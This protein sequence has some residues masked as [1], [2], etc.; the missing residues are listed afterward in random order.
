MDNT[1]TVRMATTTSINNIN[2]TINAATD[3]EVD[4]DDD[5][6]D[7]EKDE[8]G[9][10]MALVWL[11][12]ITVLIS[13]L[14]DY[15]VDTIHSAAKSWGM[16]ALFLSAIVVP[17]IGNAA[18]HAGA[19]MFAMKNKVDLAL[20]IAVGSSTQIALMVLPLLVIIG[21]MINKPLNLD[22]ESF[23]ASTLFLTVVTVAI[24]T[25]DGSSTWLLGAILIGAY[26]L[27][28]LGFFDHDDENLSG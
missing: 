25:K 20:A 8:L 12:I 27:I 22:F 4:I 5:D 14:S 10:T 26:I 17:I 3:T 28:A 19:V 13:F 16:S 18:E 23:E 1:P 24:A 9:F 21:W 15:L 2:N 6:D 11:A 7:D